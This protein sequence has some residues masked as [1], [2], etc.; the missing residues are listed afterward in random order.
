MNDCIIPVFAKDNE[1]TISHYSF[2][3]ATQDAVA[4][5]FT[6]HQVL[7]PDIRV[8]HM[9]KGRI[10]SAIG[11]PAKELAEHEKTLYYERC[12]FVIQVAGISSEVGGS[13][14]NLSIGGVR[15]YNQENLYSKKT[16]ER[17]KLFIGFSNAVCTN[18]CVSTDGLLDQVRVGDIASLSHKVHGLLENYNGD[19]HLSEM[20]ALAEVSINESTFAHVVGRMKMYHQMDKAQRNGLLPILLN[21]GQIGHLV[22]GYFHDPD[23]SGDDGRIDL[24][25]L[26]NLLTGSNKSSYIDNYLERGA[27]AYAIVRDLGNSLLNGTPNWL[28]PTI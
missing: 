3:S 26:Y 23:F 22:K 21:D 12:A 20:K 7:D 10:P 17:F 11:K 18:L 9:I 13:K 28:L 6:N 5:F 8:S 15:A 25:R 2:I 16:L 19:A 1:S 27:N 4:S 14:L 24:W